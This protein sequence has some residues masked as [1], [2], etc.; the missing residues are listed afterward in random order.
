M[1]QQ[2]RRLALVITELDVGGAERCVANLACGLDRHRFEPVVYALGVPPAEPQRQLVDQLSAAQVPVRFV[3]ADS[4][5][6]FW[7]ASRKLRLWFREQ[8]PDLVQSFL[9]HANILGIRA[10]VGA[11]IPHRV[12]G[13]RVADPTRW[14]QWLER[15]AT[16]AAQRV[17]CV[18]EAVAEFAAQCGLPKRKL[19]VIPNG[20]DTH[21][22]P[23]AAADLAALGVPRSR[24]VILFVGR[25]HHQ[26]GLDWLLHLAPE[27]LRIL[28]EHDLL[29]VGSGP[30]R[31]QYETLARELNIARR[32]HFAGWRSNVAEILAA[33]TMLVLPSRW[34]G[35]PN[36][37]L[38]AMATRLPIVTTRAEGVDEILGALCD[39]QAV[40]FGDRQGFLDRV[41]AI[42][43]NT[44]LAEELGEANR[45]RVEQVFSM[46][47]AVAAYQDLYE[48]LIG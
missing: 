16:R 46:G 42:C 3:G 45:K 28:P 14:R 10:A 30:A 2:P 17:V 21:R 1:P 4:A 20:I 34:E 32:V 43:G 23:A 11:K 39:A 5:W 26:K 9:F 18:S 15:R 47:A 13:L 31:Q 12:L 7:S 19:V 38:E 37:L 8:Q 24:R 44:A 41:L 36:V 29:L 27:L 22:Y 33:S 48:S 40:R 35:M 6:D 25:L